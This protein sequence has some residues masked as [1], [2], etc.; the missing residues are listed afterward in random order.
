VSAEALR[1]IVGQLAASASALSAV[2]A[3]LSEKATGQ[4]ITPALR[5]HLDQIAG[6]LGV[7]ESLAALDA[8]AARP[9]L[10]EL[11]VILHAATAR[12]HPFRETGWK[13]HDPKLLQAAGD[14]STGFPT[15]LRRFVP[16]LEGL[17]DRLDGDQGRF[18]DVGVGVGALAIEMVR[19]WPG[20]R[21]VGIDV[22]APSLT[23][24]R[25]NVAAAGL[26][27]RI[28]LREQAVQDL[29]DCGAFDLA[30]I[31]GAFIP[32]AVM[33]AALL[34]VRRSL[35][36]GGWLLFGSL[37]P[38]GET[39]AAALTKLRAAEWGSKPRSATEVAE[40]LETSGFHQTRALIT[41]AA[42]AAA[43]AAGR[44]E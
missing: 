31:P 5:V 16:Q 10:G 41:P 32:D 35:R 29:P 13:P 37:A 17:P 43:F 8:R 27:D 39:L 42:S 25:Q 40:L 23:L 19:L 1:E 34:R 12:L 21:V 6:L 22:W 3:L 2:G 36:P 14:V 7:R 26:Q 28:E 38:R 30:W 11:Q 4:E 24:A 33:A 44:A 15:L 18:L 9:I 20:L